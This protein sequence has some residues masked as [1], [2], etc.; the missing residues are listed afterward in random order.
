MVSFECTNKD[1]DNANVAYNFLG[2][3]ETAECGGCKT[4][5]IGTDL[6]EDPEVPSMM[7]GDLIG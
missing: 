2:N 5:L 4:V 6:R 7:L 1:C 3:P